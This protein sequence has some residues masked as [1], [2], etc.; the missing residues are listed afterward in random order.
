M[1]WFSSLCGFISKSAK[2]VANVVKNVGSAVVS[3]VSAAGK[4]IKT[5]SK[6]I[7]AG[8]MAVAGV[9]ICAGSGGLLAPIGAGL[10]GAGVAGLAVAFNKN[11][12]WGDFAKASL[13]GFVAGA[14]TTLAAPFIAGVAA[15]VA[16]MSSNLILSWVL[17]AG[18]S[19][20]GF[21]GVAVSTNAINNLIHGHNPM[22]NW[23]SSA[24]C[25]ALI[26]FVSPL[27][28]GTGLSEN[29]RHAFT[30]FET[31][32]G[33]FT[34]KF[35]GNIAISAVVNRA[36]T[37]NW[38]LRNACLNGALYAAA[39]VRG[40]RFRVDQPA[41]YNY[42]PQY[43][44]NDTRVP[45]AT[46]QPANP[47]E[48]RPRPDQ[49]PNDD[50]PYTYRPQNDAVSAPQA[51]QTPAETT[52]LIVQVPPAAVLQPV[53]EPTENQWAQQERAQLQ[54]QSVPPPN[55]RAP[56]TA[57]AVRPALPPQTAQT[58][59]A[60]APAP[61]PLPASRTQFDPPLQSTATAPVPVH[62]VQAPPPPHPTAPTAQRAAL[63]PTPAA[64]LM[65]APASTAQTST[66]NHNASTPLAQ[67][68]TASNTPKQANIIS[69]TTAPAQQSAA[70]A[71]L[72]AS[73]P[74][75]T[76]AAQATPP[77]QVHPHT[78]DLTSSGANLAQQQVA[79]S[80][81][82]AAPRA[83]QVH[84]APVQ[85]QHTAAPQSAQRQ[86][87][88]ALDNS[89]RQPVC[90]VI[91]EIRFINEE[92][93]RADR[94]RER[95]I[96]EQ[97]AF[98][99]QH[100][101]IPQY[102]YVRVTENVRLPV[103]I[104]GQPG[105]SGGSTQQKAYGGSGF[106]SSLTANTD[107]MTSGFIP[108]QL[109]GNQASTAPQTLTS[110]SPP[111]TANK[112]PL[113]IPV[114]LYIEMNQRYEVLHPDAWP[115]FSND[116][117]IV[118][119]A[120][121][122]GS[123]RTM[124]IH[125]LLYHWGYT[126][127]K[128]EIVKRSLRMGVVMY[129]LPEMNLALVDCCESMDAVDEDSIAPA[130]SLLELFCYL[131]SDHRIH[132]VKVDDRTFD[133]IQLD[134]YVESCQRRMQMLMGMGARVSGVGGNRVTLVLRYD[135]LNLGQKESFSKFK[136]T[137]KTN[138]ETSQ[139]NITEIFGDKKLAD[140]NEVEKEL[141]E[142]LINQAPFDEDMHLLMY[143]PTDY[144][145]DDIGTYSE[146]QRA[147]AE[148]I[149]HDTSSFGFSNLKN[150]IC[151]VFPKLAADKPLNDEIANSMNV[152]ASSM[153]ADG[154]QYD[155][156]GYCEKV[157][158]FLQNSENE[159]LCEKITSFSE[160]VANEIKA[161]GENVGVIP[162]FK[163]VIGFG[164]ILV[165][166]GLATSNVEVKNKMITLGLEGFTFFLRGAANS[167]HFEFTAIRMAI[168]DFNALDLLSNECIFL[169]FERA[170]IVLQFTAMYG[171]RL[172]LL[173]FDIFDK[174]LKALHENVKKPSEEA[175]DI[176][177]RLLQMLGVLLSFDTSKILGEEPPA[178]D[179]A[180]YTLSEAQFVRLMGV[181]GK[182]VDLMNENLKFNRKLTKADVEAHYE[183]LM[184]YPA[185]FFN[186]SEI[187][188]RD[189]KTMDD[190]NPTQAHVFSEALLRSFYASMAFFFSE[191]L[192]E[193]HHEFISQPNEHPE[194]VKAKLKLWI[195][196]IELSEES[197]TLFQDL[198]KKTNIKMW[199]LDTLR[200]S[201]SAYYELSLKLANSVI[202]ADSQSAEVA[203]QVAN[204]K[205]RQPRIATLQTILERERYQKI[206]EA[207]GE[208]RLL[209]INDGHLP[210]VLDV[211]DKR[212]FPVPQ[213]ASVFIW[214]LVRLL[215]HGVDDD[216]QQKCLD[217]Y[218]ERRHI[219][220]DHLAE[221]YKAIVKNP[222]P[223]S[224][225]S[226]T[227][228]MMIGTAHF[229]NQLLLFYYY[230]R[231]NKHFYHRKGE[232]DKQITECQ[233]WKALM[234]ILAA[235]SRDA[236]GR[237]RL[238]T[239]SGEEEMSN[240]QLG[241]LLCFLYNLALTS[242][243]TNG[244]IIAN[245]NHQAVAELKDTAT[246]EWKEMKLSVKSLAKL[247]ISRQNPDVNIRRC[248]YVYAKFAMSLAT[249]KGNEI[250]LNL[251]QSYAPELRFF[252]GLFDTCTREQRLI[253]ANDESIKAQIA[254][255]EA[256]L[257]RLEKLGTQAVQQNASAHVGTILRDISNK[258]STS[259]NVR[260]A[261][262]VTFAI[263]TIFTTFSGHDFLNGIRVPID[264]QIEVLEKELIHRYGIGIGHA[265][266]IA[267]RNR[268]NA[269]FFN[270]NGF[271]R[272]LNHFEKVLAAPA[273]DLKLK[274][275]SRKVEEMLKPE[276]VMN[277]MTAFGYMEAMNKDK[278]VLQANPDHLSS[279]VHELDFFLDTL[280]YIQKS[281]KDENNVF[282][283]HLNMPFQ[284]LAHN[285]GDKQAFEQCHLPMCFF[286]QATSGPSKVHLLSIGDLSRDCRNELTKSFGNYSL[287]RVQ[288]DIKNL[289]H[290]YQAVFYKS[291][292]LSKVSEDL[293]DVIAKEYRDHCC[294][295]SCILYTDSQRTVQLNLNKSI[296]ESHLHPA[297]FLYCCVA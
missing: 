168:N 224:E 285:D 10:I 253:D 75:I 56:E 58:P 20:V 65:D 295:Q 109:P 173:T 294:K 144:S 2:K 74:K 234:W 143:M 55:E 210:R 162:S 202:Y 77:P 72:P 189:K 181:F 32:A 184:A 158:N 151:N 178:S 60:Q 278:L 261:P 132:H 98:D 62:T 96:L 50:P 217:V 68:P 127:D 270:S 86:K 83:E 248:A 45:E 244:D 280:R 170:W 200:D 138:Q 268:S 131:I 59:A 112:V 135:S 260:P 123:G 44:F 256:R 37:G 133:A 213:K 266:L 129:V 163:Y 238:K 94:E 211:F 7:V 164:A 125:S 3:A 209:L 13:G 49:Q 140:L 111:A 271:N 115:E 194:I 71:P 236:L 82:A 157:S 193:H 150:W 288:I 190:L 21:A 76:P 147:L 43:V 148:R 89:F 85:P 219:L 104:D 259:N 226:A 16:A 214:H 250:S 247:N 197:E 188:L 176:C 265:F 113:I 154:V 262:A 274:L 272:L 137:R 80:N 46:P 34:M 88:N 84:R 70:T 19:V 284:R 297:A 66:T 26:G 293:S 17:A 177:V 169:N 29:I 42:E 67:T 25:G 54:P 11:S 159:C 30:N 106:A 24:I 33:S 130:S 290:V 28:N 93:Q 134:K 119:V 9:A 243:I 252:V 187:A 141:S 281:H 145:L 47:L 31:S 156:T 63:V 228:N 186:S 69:M 191:R 107:P 101:R 258:P 108:D 171:Y 92:K 235:I 255:E 175:R 153:A 196:L 121:L 279:I 251:R 215:C 273:E 206:L 182:K 291:T 283:C 204:D 269:E 39:N 114:I 87:L 220:I 185:K 27:I 126:L 36:Q 296:E 152:L 276:G 73:A 229:I 286:D 35:L 216:D 183:K 275:V 161:A 166:E 205:V 124:M 240:Q 4:F 282:E 118:T 230:K 51:E 167:Q 128:V 289:T 57:Q 179:P 120:G 23:K 142:D 146:E 237:S 18:V 245:T 203:E 40:A 64:P 208:F 180:K 91:D 267:V 207:Y 263:E 139:T 110:T 239:R 225:R 6:K 15:N 198:L 102:E 227:I 136:E 249:D 257:Q 97:T 292:Q 201:E 199:I 172:E 52:P 242:D 192:L 8:A 79:N 61:I 22:N 117:R 221:I 232:N 222:P 105:P 287:I 41:S 277:M 264:N 103:G 254:A 48:E 99:Q 218:L 231:D 1:G 246:G 116:L 212:P 12:T 223:D 5:H 90:S 100:Q 53:P 174:A 38:N 195:Q 160:T 81:D 95:Q 155:I 14:L 149:N 233:S 165:R 122:Q 241:V 78:E